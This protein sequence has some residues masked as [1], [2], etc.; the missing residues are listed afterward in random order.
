MK[1][2]LIP[3]I[4]LFMMFSFTLYSD[5]S[6]I[7]PELPFTHNG[8]IYNHAFAQYMWG[9]YTLIQYCRSEKYAVV[10]DSSNGTL[11][12]FCGGANDD[13]SN[14]GLLFPEGTAGAI[15]YCDRNDICGNIAE[16]QTGIM[17]GY[18]FVDLPLSSHVYSSV[19]VIDRYSGEVIL[20]ANLGSPEMSDDTVFLTPADSTPL[21][22]RTPLILVH[23]NNLENEKDYGWGKYL[24]RLEGDRRFNRIYKVYLV[25]WDSTRP[26]LENGLKL[27]AAIDFLPELDDK[28]IVF[29][30][31]SRGGIIARYFMNR[32]T[33][34][35]GSCAGQLGG[36]K[37]KWLLTLG[38]P[39]RGSPGADPIWTYFSIDYN[40]PYIIAKSLS[41][42]YF[43]LGIWDIETHKHLLWDDADNILTS[44]YVGWYSAL[45][46]ADTCQ[47][48][49]SS[50]S[51]LIQL[52]EEELYH[53]KIIAYGG[54]N[55]SKNL[56]RIM[57]LWLVAVYA[58][59]SGLSLILTWNDHMKLNLTTMLMARMPIIPNGY[60]ADCNPTILN[61]ID[62]TFRPFQANDGMVPLPSALFLKPGSSDV[63]KLKKKKISYNKKELKK[64]CQV[65][66]CIVS[67]ESVDHLDFLND[68]KSITSVL[69]KLL[70]IE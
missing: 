40:Y 69:N 66:E 41:G 56:D 47:K 61:P 23:G 36:E 31:Y 51:D 29:L 38:T 64:A 70:K 25:S 50:Q 35:N 8:I 13:Y 57:A 19:D 12:A 7:Q 42:I 54:N 53:K 32:Y 52:N 58:D 59:Y 4:V 15:Q 11:A 28:E 24:G 3:T 34:K 49:M 43:N 27:G 5:A 17:T 39:H 26:N 33:L 22:Q 45:E 18:N 20:R 9:D 68:N 37:T 46:D 2:L 63:F 65:A 44:D 10:Y 6:F 16:Y 48:M 21:D 1:K 55:Y 14:A 60:Q 62:D 67:P 30:T